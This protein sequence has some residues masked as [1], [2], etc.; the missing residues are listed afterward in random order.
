VDHV[1]DGVANSP[2][3]EPR[4]SAIVKQQLYGGA[5]ELLEI[6]CGGQILRVK[7]AARGPLSGKQEFSFSAHDAVPVSE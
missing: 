4:F 3:S 2:A 5:S 1:A 7:I 6:D